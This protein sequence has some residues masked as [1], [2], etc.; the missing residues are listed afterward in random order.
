[1]TTISLLTDF[2]LRDG[3]VGVMKGVIWGIAPKVSIADLSHNIAPQNV[4]EASFTL[5]RSAFYFP[6]DSV[7]IVVVDPGVGTPRKPIA[8][9]IGEQYF[10]GPDNG[11]FTGV[12]E[13][14]EREDWPMQIFHTDD[15]AYWRSEISSVF[16]GRD[17]FAPI[18]AHL[19]AGIPLEKLGMPL[20]DPI[21]LDLPKPER[22]SQGWRA[23]VAHIDHFG[24][25]YTSLRR[26][27]LDGNMLV[28]VNLGG[29]TVKGL[30][31]AFGERDPGEL[32]ALY[33]ST[34]YLMI[35]EVNGDAGARLD[36]KV[37][38]QVQVA[39]QDE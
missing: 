33:S 16:H 4:R 12:I 20:N 35:S 23:E 1:M 18:G 11:V 19:A 3:N 2:G 39:V 25:I 26:T 38:D 10:V 15:P 14:G 31:R 37:G 29:V 7:H 17:I 30:V 5:L 36:A 34:G 22:T 27:H 6:A 32:I 21:L 24:N 13:H 8:L 9:H 28:S